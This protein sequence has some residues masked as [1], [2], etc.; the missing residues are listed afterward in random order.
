MKS[1]IKKIIKTAIRSIVDFSYGTRFGQY[2]ETMIINSAMERCIKVSHDDFSFKFASHNSLCKWRYET[3]SS[4]ESE[5]LEWINTKLSVSILW[6]I[7]ANVSSYSIYA[8]K[9]RN[10]KVWTFEPSV[11]NLE[12]FSRNIYLNELTNNI[13]VV[14]IALSDKLC[15]RQ[16]RMTSTG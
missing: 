10:C 15:S 16:M 7:G 2:F 5:T 3:F 4:K 1:L 11:F 14:P 8:T 12:L 13:C 6:D 9:K